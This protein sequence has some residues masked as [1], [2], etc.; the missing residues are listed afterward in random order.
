MYCSSC[1]TGVGQEASFCGSCGQPIQLR[2]SADDTKASPSAPI[3]PNAKQPTNTGQVQGTPAESNGLATAALVLGILSAGFFEFV[4]V[5]IAALVVS[6]FA[7]SKST[8]LANK[9]QKKTGK[10][11]SIAGLI[12]GGV[13]LFTW[14]GWN[15]LGW[16]PGR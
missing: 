1:G 5:P 15:V 9:G 3:S 12:L 6:S 8:S 16:G 11:K 10:G 14:F 7:L 4:F 13:Y 2:K